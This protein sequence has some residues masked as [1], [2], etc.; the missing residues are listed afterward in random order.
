[1]YSCNSLFPSLQGCDTF[2]ITAAVAL[3]MFTVEDSLTSSAGFEEAARRNGAYEEDA[4]QAKAPKT[5][6][7]SR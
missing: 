5:H 6:A 2:T 4:V 7:S 1:M 3:K